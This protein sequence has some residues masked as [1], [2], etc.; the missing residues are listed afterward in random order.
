MAGLG[1]ILFASDF[2]PASRPAFALARRLA[3]ALGARLV[4]FHAYDGVVPVAA[5]S[6]PMATTL[7]PSVVEDLWAESRR[8]GQRG[9]GRLAAAARKDRLRVKVRLAIGPAAPAIVKAARRERAGLV[10]VGTHGRT[11]LS[12]LLLGS[13]AERVVR[14]SPC[15]VLTVA[16][17]GR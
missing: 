11:G 14:T 13:V 16:R 2:S 4:L 9:L 12:R 15:P 10:V 6:T 1:P 17:R 8:A 5:G 7:P 3:G